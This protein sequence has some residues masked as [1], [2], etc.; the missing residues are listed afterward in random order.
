MMCPGLHWAKD[1]IEQ[2]YR[3]VIN[4]KSITKV[5]KI[6]Q[7][8][9]QGQYVLG[10][11]WAAAGSHGTYCVCMCL[12]VWTLAQPQSGLFEKKGLKAKGRPGYPTGAR[13]TTQDL[14]MIAQRWLW[15]DFAMFL[16]D[17][18]K[19][20]LFFSTPAKLKTAET[21]LSLSLHM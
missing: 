10:D 17:V 1:C 15:V 5:R 18:D 6:T 2:V 20:N 13:Q 21:P 14:A 11:T 12:C 19:V 7:S 9:L 4:L 3:T 8:G 16:P